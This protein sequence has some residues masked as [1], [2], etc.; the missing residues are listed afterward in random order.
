MILRF[1]LAVGAE[2][3][4]FIQEALY[5]LAHS[6]MLVSCMHAPWSLSSM[7]KSA[8]SCLTS[9]PEISQIRHHK[10]THRIS[11]V[12][13]VCHLGTMPAH[14][15]PAVSPLSKARSCLSSAPLFSCCVGLSA[16]Q[17]LGQQAGV[18]SSR[19]ATCKLT[20]AFLQSVQV[21]WSHAEAEHVSL[22]ICADGHHSIHHSMQAGPYVSGQLLDI[23]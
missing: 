17:A 8:S 1:D 3:D 9:T 6:D 10:K 15:W 7:R 2:G 16:H 12:I 13:D 21:T 22:L 23:A 4:L 11:D 18:A 19:Q 20:G 14:D 5:G